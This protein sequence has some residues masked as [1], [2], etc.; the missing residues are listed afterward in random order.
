MNE[1]LNYVSFR[2]EFFSLPTFKDKY[3]VYLANEF[4]DNNQH[5]YKER[6]LSEVEMDLVN[7]D[8]IAKDLEL[9]L[10]HIAKH[11]NYIFD[12]F[13]IGGLHSIVYVNPYYLYIYIPIDIDKGDK[14]NEE[15]LESDVK[16][17]FNMDILKNLAQIQNISCIVSHN[18]KISPNKLSK[19]EVLDK[20][21]FPQIYP[22]DINTGRYSDSHQTDQGIKQILIRDIQKALDVKNKIFFYVSITSISTYDY[23]I[24]EDSYENYQELY[25]IALNE[26]ARCFK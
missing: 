3:V 23:F 2:I 12:D 16:R 5:K 17:I 15:T 8:E 11:Q 9:S 1:F 25:N 22:N 21:A 19:G 18:L 6:T 13:F 24:K 14:I 26:A 7:V 20:D 4:P 10:V